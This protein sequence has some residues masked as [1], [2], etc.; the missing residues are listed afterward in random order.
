MILAVLSQDWVED[1]HL[2]HTKKGL[3][4]RFKIFDLLALSLIIKS[5]SNNEVSNSV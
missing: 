5:D 1:R 2:D 3:S 4:V